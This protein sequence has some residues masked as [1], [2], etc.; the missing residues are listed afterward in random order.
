MKPIICP[1]RAGS[2][3]AHSVRWYSSCLE[4]YGWSPR[5]Q[6]P[7]RGQNMAGRL[8]VQISE[9]V[10]TIDPRQWPADSRQA[11]A[12]E[13]L[14]SLIFDRLVSFDDHGNPQPALAVSW[15]YDAPAKRWQFLIRKGVKFT[16]GSTLTPEVAAI[17]LQQ[18]LGN[19]FDVSATSD[20]V[21][22]QADHSLP[23]FPSML[24]AGRYFIFHTAET[25]RSWVPG[26]FESRNGLLAQLRKSS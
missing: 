18:L 20:N 9:R 16:D 14:D 19:S 21:N 13:R 4:R 3:S 15:Q 17:A 22:I 12:T 10:A 24:A 7:R 6:R 2:K 23:D 1:F 25:A 8:R 5:V 26:H 11:A